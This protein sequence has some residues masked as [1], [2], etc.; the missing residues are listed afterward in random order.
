ME[1][2]RVLV[3]ARLVEPTA[4]TIRFDGTDL[5]RLD[6]R[7]LHRQRRHMQMVFQDPFSSL[8]PRHKVAEILGEPLEV[9]RIGD[10]RS[11][12]ERVARLLEMVGLEPQA[13]T[14]YPHEF[15]GGQRQRLSIARAIALDPKLVVADEPVSALAVSIRSQILNLLARSEERRVGKACV[16][17]CRARW[18]PDL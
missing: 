12:R 11:R 5:A 15:S 16:S 8:N 4:G 3:R 17:K 2:R 14:R 13:A 18:T 7:G 9:H 1:F 6:R 10:R